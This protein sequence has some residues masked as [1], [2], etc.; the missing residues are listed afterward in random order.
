MTTRVR[1]TFSMRRGVVICELKMH[2]QDHP[3]GVIL[4]LG[5]QS[6]MRVESVMSAYRGVELISMRPVF[7]G[8]SVNASTGPDATFR[9]IENFDDLFNRM[10]QDAR[11]VETRE[12]GPGAFTLPTG[13]G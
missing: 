2:G 6:V 3:A 4:D 7:Q 11:F 8:L 5:T 1:S 9:Y 10:G 12:L 13:D